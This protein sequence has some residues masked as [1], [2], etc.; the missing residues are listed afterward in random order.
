MNNVLRSYKCD[1]RRYATVASGRAFT[2]S[3][4]WG[5]RA[6]VDA[7]GSVRVW[8]DVAGYWTLC[9]ALSR[10]QVAYVRRTAVAS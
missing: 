7:D 9:H 8:D 4:Q 6:R 10:A 2:G 3:S 1:V 5:Y